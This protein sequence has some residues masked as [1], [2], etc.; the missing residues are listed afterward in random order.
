MN[1]LERLARAG[2]THAVVR[3]IT[4]DPDPGPKHE[5]EYERSRHSGAGNCV[6][7]VAEHHRRHPHDFWGADA[8][9]SLCVCGL[10]AGA[11]VHGAGS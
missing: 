2:R 9:P 10:P 5:Y 4:R 3:E 7:G 1:A 11:R 6:C 8:A